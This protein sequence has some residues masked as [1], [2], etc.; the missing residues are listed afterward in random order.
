M[1]LN[2]DK[3]TTTGT[4]QILT[5]PQRYVEKNRLY[6]NIREQ[7]GRVLSDAQVQLLPR[8]QAENAKQ[9]TFEREWALR[10]CTLRRFQ[11]YL[12]KRFQHKS[13]NILDFGCGNGW[14]ALNLAKN[15]HRLLWAVDINLPEL[16]QGAR[17]A[18]A[19][20]RTNI[21]FVFADIFENNL[22]EKKF[23]LIVLAAAVQYFP[24]LKK[25]IA[26]LKRL[27]RPGGE[28]HF[29][30][31]PFYPTETRRRAAQSGSLRYYSNLGFPEM[32]QGYNHHLWAD[33][34]ALGGKNL[35]AGI[36]P[37]LLQRLKI[38]PPFP[39]VVLT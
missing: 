19:L 21:Q 16:E 8:F 20:G 28:I 3:K 18:K 17:I 34:A 24:D 10:A 9:K 27:L 30:D 39:W 2:S 33:V 14:M 32:A 31:S 12:E 4:V 38:L 26:A 37:R 22:P 11:N 15:P 7:E 35:N 23:D 5:D 25:L 13:L 36:Y 6:L 1:N 29:L